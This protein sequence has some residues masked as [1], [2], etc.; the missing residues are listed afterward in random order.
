MSICDCRE[1]CIC[2][3]IRDGCKSC[4]QEVVPHFILLAYYIK[5]VTTSWTYCTKLVEVFGPYFHL[6]TC[7]FQIST[8]ILQHVEEDRNDS[9]G[10]GGQREGGV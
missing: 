8:A 3:V 1:R 10:D 2:V 7:L 6:M 9:R 4:V 5:W